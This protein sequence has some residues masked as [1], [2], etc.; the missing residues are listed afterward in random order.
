MMYLDSTPPLLLLWLACAGAAAQE[1]FSG[2]RQV[3]TCSMRTRRCS[4]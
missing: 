1:T 4:P 2:A 3:S